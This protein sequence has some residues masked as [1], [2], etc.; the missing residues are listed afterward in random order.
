MQQKPSYLEASFDE[1]VFEGRNQTY[2]SFVLRQVVR[3][4]TY[5][6]LMIFVSATLIAI[7][8]VY[9]DFI[10]DDDIIFSP[11]YSFTEVSLTDPPPILDI[12]PPAA[13]PALMPSE[14]PIAAEIEVKAD[15]QVLDKDLTTTDTKGDSTSTGTSTEGTNN[16]SVVNGTGKT[17]YKSLEEMP[18][19]PG[20][21]KGI[22]KYLSDNLEYP[23]V[24]KANRITGTVMVVFVVNED[25][26][27]SNVQ[28]AQGIGG[29]CDQEA[30]RVV[31]SMTRW[32]PGKQ[33]GKPEACYMKMPITFRLN[34]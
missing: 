10:K 34:D 13:P 9:I 19:Y 29:G 14:T 12:L 7:A 28:V 32:K 4:H 6:A 24:A 16:T 18:Y 20:G 33:G 30:V 8:S 5:I 3:K 22:Q 23:E 17:I 27:V 15:D 26:S 31:E 11:D 2:G 25:G 21:N 1:I